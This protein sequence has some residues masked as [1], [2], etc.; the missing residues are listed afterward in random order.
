MVR[1]TDCWNDDGPAIIVIYG[2]GEVSTHDNGDTG[3]ELITCWG[4]RGS[5]CVN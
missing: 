2:V 1:G 3:L 5:A 4:A